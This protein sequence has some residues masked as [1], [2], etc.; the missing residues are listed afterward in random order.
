M[1]PVVKWRD[2]IM[3]PIGI[4]ENENWFLNWTFQ[5]SPTSNNF[6]SLYLFEFTQ[7]LFAICQNQFLGLN[8]LWLFL[9]GATRIVGTFLVYWKLKILFKYQNN[10]WKSKL[11]ALKKNVTDLKFSILILKMRLKI[12]KLRHNG[13]ACGLS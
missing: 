6:L 10:L 9:G 11:N 7:S 4:P 13:N 2:C 12:E 1:G 5:N 8:Y 3:L